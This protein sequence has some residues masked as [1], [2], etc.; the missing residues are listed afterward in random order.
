MVSPTQPVP[1]KPS[2]PS[3]TALAHRRAYNA[4]QL[5]RAQ[6]EFGERLREY[7]RARLDADDA[8]IAA[9]ARDLAI[10]S[11]QLADAWDYK[12]RGW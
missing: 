2:E 11:L 7:S 12:A 9:V 4:V 1:S 5:V 3:D 6:A 10:A 8:G